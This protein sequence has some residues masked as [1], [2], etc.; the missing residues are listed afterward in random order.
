MSPIKQCKEFWRIFNMLKDR[1]NKSPSPEARDLMEV[2]E[3]VGHI[4]PAD[5]NL[6][7]QSLRDKY[8]LK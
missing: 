4:V 5:R 1:G 2:D 8:P 3:A 6:W 7:P